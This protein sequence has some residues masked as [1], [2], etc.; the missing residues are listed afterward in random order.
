MSPLRSGSSRGASSP[1]GVSDSVSGPVSVTR[2]GRASVNPC[3]S[4]AGPLRYHFRHR[5]AA[6]L[7]PAGARPRRRARHAAQ[8]VAAAE[9]AQLQTDRG[10]GRPQPRPLRAEGRR[11]SLAAVGDARARAG[12]AR[13]VAR[14]TLPGGP[15][16]RL[17]PPSPVRVGLATLAAAP[18]R[19]PDGPGTATA[20]AASASPT[21]TTGAMI[22]I[23]SDVFDR[24]MESNYASQAP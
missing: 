2:G 15:R 13:P 3:S 18:A 8:R 19:S 5:A 12:A 6:V 11:Q 23:P 21:E 14:S 1:D 9:R 17:R 24:A 4:P 10:T 7:D 20:S 22:L 16:C